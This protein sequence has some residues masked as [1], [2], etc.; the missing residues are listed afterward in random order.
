MATDF[1]EKRERGN[2]AGGPMVLLDDQAVPMSTMS[3][4]RIYNIVTKPHHVE[5]TTQWHCREENGPLKYIR[6]VGLLTVILVG[7]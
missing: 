3:D 5:T 2:Y 7:C 6:C 4:A 1:I